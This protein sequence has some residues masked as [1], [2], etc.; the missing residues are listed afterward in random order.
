M[1]ETYND[2]L[3]VIFTKYN[4]LIQR[5]VSYTGDD[6]SN[7]I[8]KNYP[9]NIEDIEFCKNHIEWIS[10]NWNCIYYSMKC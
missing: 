3:D 2:K 8:G 6:L 9:D 7:M 4:A 1:M 10:R 5:N